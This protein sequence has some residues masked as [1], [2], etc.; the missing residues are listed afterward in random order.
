[1]FEL[2]GKVA[3]VT[4]GY[5]ALGT[6]MCRGLAE[7]GATVVVIGRDGEKAAALAGE[8]GGESMGM[9]ADVLDKDALETAAGQ[10][11]AR[12]ERIDVLVNAA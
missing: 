4:G 8:L 9:A 11:M 6:G 3:I 1:M 7:A 12:Y 2:N 5:G 10:I